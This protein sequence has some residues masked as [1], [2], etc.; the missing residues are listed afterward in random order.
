[1]ETTRTEQF[2]KVNDELTGASRDTFRHAVLNLPAFQAVMY[3]AIVLILWQGGKQMLVGGMLVGD[4]T[5]FLSYVLQVMNSLMMISNVFL[6]LTRSLA[7]ARRI[8]E[9][10]E[11]GPRAH[12][13]HRSGGQVPERGDRF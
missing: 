1:M 10:L 12:R 8:R 11:G 5:A 3:T 4:L 7:S 9:V 6:L 13:R 2:S